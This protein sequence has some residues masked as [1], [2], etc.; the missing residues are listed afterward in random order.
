MFVCVLC[1]YICSSMWVLVWM[2]LWVCVIYM[3]K[4]ERSLLKGCNMIYDFNHLWAIH[5]YYLYIKYMSCDF[6]FLFYR[7]I[8]VY[9]TYK[10][11][12]YIIHIC[13]YTDFKHILKHERVGLVF[14]FY[15]IHFSVSSSFSFTLLSVFTVY[16]N[17]DMDHVSF[18]G[19]YS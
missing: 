18:V 6:F 2:W 9:F 7:D 8:H 16:K 17:K 10:S 4:C 11:T 15:F 13:M 19:V 1:L 5:T 12:L 14:G 3:Y